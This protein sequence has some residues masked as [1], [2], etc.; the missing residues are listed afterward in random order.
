MT[1]AARAGSMPRTQ[2]RP[3]SVAAGAGGQVESV[4]GGARWN[5]EMTRILR[6]A[7]GV[8]DELERARS[9]ED[10]QLARRQA[11][12]CRA[13]ISAHIPSIASR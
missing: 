11:E 9:T 3:G 4:A 5:E 1:G 12:A 10:R 2:P 13:L 6:E 8:R 7:A